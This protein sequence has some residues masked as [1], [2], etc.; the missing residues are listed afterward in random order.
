[1]SA[2]IPLSVIT[3]SWNVKDLL[4]ECIRS[5]AQSANGMGFEH[6]VIDNAS[7]DGSAAAVER[8][9]PHVV[10][11]RNQENTGFACANNIAARR[12]R[13]RYLLFLNPDTKVL[14]DALPTMVGILDA[15]PQIGVLGS[16]LL[17]SDLSWSRDM[18]YRAP[19]LRTLI[20]E[21]LMLS[22]L[23]PIPALVPGIM[24]S[25]DFEGL[26]ECD[27]VSGASMMVRRE[28]PE[29]WNE[30]IF[31]FAEEIDYCD[32]VRQGGWKV[33]CTAD[34]RVVHYSGS[35]MSKQST[36]FL[37]GRTSGMAVYLRQHR[38]PATATIGL[39]A[40]R[41]GYLSRIAYHRLAY[42]VSRNP[43]ALEKSRRLRQYL[44]LD[45]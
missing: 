39:Q 42:R 5:A 23:I 4:L 18:G 7:D 37:D 3:V 1:M 36:D 45:A 13:G 40:I 9:F 29:M 33:C 24:R 43:A 41:L 8:E 28:I 20:N 17:T 15:Q 6:I 10:L 22:R 21:C 35:S 44:R 12:A 34:A 32:R 31:F 25:A 2:E 30:E 16:K 14:D 19:T 38:G 27:W 11:I 26:E